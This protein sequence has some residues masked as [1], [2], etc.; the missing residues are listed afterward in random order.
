MDRGQIVPSA[1]QPRDAAWDAAWV[2]AT[3]LVVRD[4]IT[5]EHFDTLYGPWRDVIG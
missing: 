3:A 5:L 4:L 1:M 2:A